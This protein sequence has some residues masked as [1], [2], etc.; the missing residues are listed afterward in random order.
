MK[1][2]TEMNQEEI[3]NTFYICGSISFLI[4]GIANIITHS[5]NWEFML[6]SLKVSSVMGTFFNFVV[7][8]F[9]GAMYTGNKKQKEGLGKF[10]EKE[11]EE[12]IQDLENGN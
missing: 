11:A 5:I 6:L 4:I 3:L 1:L 10:N 12:V 7:A 9:F 8:W 2:I